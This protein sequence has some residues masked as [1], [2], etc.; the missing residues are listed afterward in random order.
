[1]TDLTIEKRPGWDWI[2]VYDDEDGERA[3]MTVFGCARIEDAVR[4]ARS[5]F[6][7]DD[8]VAILE[9]RRAS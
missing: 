6:Q 8:P 1:M 9:V 2:V 5:S 3:E 4:D 7:P